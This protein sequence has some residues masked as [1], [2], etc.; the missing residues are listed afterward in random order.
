MDGISFRLADLPLN[1]NRQRVRGFTLNPAVASMDTVP[2]RAGLTME[3]AAQKLG[4]STFTLAELGINHQ[5]LNLVRMRDL[6]GRTERFYVD[7][8][9]LRDRNAPNEQFNAIV[10][11]LGDEK[12]VL[13]DFDLVDALDQLKDNHENKAQLL[14]AY[15][16]TQFD[17]YDPNYQLRILGAMGRVISVHGLP[18]GN[19]GHGLLGSA[20]RIFRSRTTETCCQFHEESGWFCGGNYQDILNDLPR[21]L[22]AGEFRDILS[23]YFG[24]KKVFIDPA[25]IPFYSYLLINDILVRDFEG[26]AQAYKAGNQG[27][28]R[29]K[30]HGIHAALRSFGMPMAYYLKSGTGEIYFLTAETYEEVEAQRGQRPG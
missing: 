4:V 19:N 29:S 26:Q 6:F 18:V 24:V 9:K 7:P 27:A 17:S 12:T 23:T 3:T 8:Q 10:G 21:Y 2:L 30:T 16:S 15:Y 28:M 14:F 13:A 11:R 1:V 25:L 22:G 5:G 20:V